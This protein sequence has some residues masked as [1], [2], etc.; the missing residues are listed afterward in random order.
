MEFDL[1]RLRRGELIAAVGGILLFVF[2]FFFDWYGD[3][4]GSWNGWHGHTVLRWLMLLTILAA[5]ALAFATA[6]QRTPALPVTGAVILTGLAALTT[7][8]VAYRVIINEPGPNAAIDVKAGAWLGLLS[9]VAI[10]IG[11]Y[12][13]MRDEGTSLTD[14]AEQ[15]RAAFDAVAPHAEE[16]SEGSVPPPSATAAPPPPPV[17]PPP[18]V[19]PPPMPAAEEP[20]APPPPPPPPV[21]E[22]PLA[23]PPPPPP[24][25]A[26][27]EPAADLGPPP[28]P[29]DSP[30][31]EEPPEPAPPPV[32]PPSDE[33]D[34]PG[35]GA[36]Q[37]SEPPAAS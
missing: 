36:P 6:T 31:A 22:E 1:S 34:H 15:A 20:A 3:S 16:G 8:L 13:S 25:P 5:L 18:P 27:E 33:E 35:Y 37:P 24:A 4:L 12:L 21:A 32:G 11:G 17:A 10:T 23:P 26:A 7:V 2:L 29:L 28:S 19:P 30:P 14:A 9:L